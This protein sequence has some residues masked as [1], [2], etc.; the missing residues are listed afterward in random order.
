MKLTYK[1]PEIQIRK[2]DFPSDNLFTSLS[3]DP[4]EPPEGLNPDDH[5]IFGG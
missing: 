3:G 4:V 2:Y 1:E 5:P